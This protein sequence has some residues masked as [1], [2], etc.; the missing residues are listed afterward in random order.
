MLCVKVVGQLSSCVWVV[1]ALLVT[2]A[3]LPPKRGCRFLQDARLAPLGFSG[4][5]DHLMSFFT[6][7]F[8]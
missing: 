7:F 2:L 3:L 1:Y 4:T 8:R 6:S 5:T